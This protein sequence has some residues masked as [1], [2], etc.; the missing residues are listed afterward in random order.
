M[1]FNGNIWNV[2]NQK[3]SQ[4][5]ILDERFYFK[6]ND[7]QPKKKS[8]S[9]EYHNWN[10]SHWYLLCNDQYVLIAMKLAPLNGQVW[11]FGSFDTFKQYIFVPFHGIHWTKHIYGIRWKSASK[12]DRCWN[13]QTSIQSA[14][15]KKS[16][17]FLRHIAGVPVNS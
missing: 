5:S 9:Y 6:S 13:C 4:N 16:N 7:N 1:L 2:R 8:K 12:P 17:F 14:R 10:V 11:H 3:I 15:V